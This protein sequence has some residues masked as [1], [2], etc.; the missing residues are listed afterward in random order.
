M[1]DPAAGCLDRIHG[2]VDCP[3]PGFGFRFDHVWAAAGI[4]EGTVFARDSVSRGFSALLNGLGAPVAGGH[5]DARCA[6]L[7]HSIRALARHLAPPDMP[8]FCSA[9]S[10]GACLAVD[11]QSR[12]GHRLCRDYLL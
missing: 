5:V 8:V 12:P 2:V 9:A 10:R 3:I 1:A 4:C 7:N 11:A 6:F